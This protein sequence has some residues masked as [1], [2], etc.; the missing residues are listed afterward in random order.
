MPL[1]VRFKL[2]SLLLRF[3]LHWSVKF[4]NQIQTHLP[5]SAPKI[6]SWIASAAKVAA[7][8]LDPSAGDVI[9]LAR[10]GN[11]TIRELYAYKSIL[12]TASELFKS[13][14]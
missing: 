12:S 8:L 2:I 14:K 1:A 5:S 11:D 10:D 9:F 7:S 13:R 3:L 6:P 4:T